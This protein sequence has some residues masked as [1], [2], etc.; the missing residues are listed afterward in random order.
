MSR[1]VWPQAMQLFSRGLTDA[2][3]SAVRTALAEVSRHNS[4]APKFGQHGLPVALRWCSL[5]A[6]GFPRQ[7]FQVFRRSGRVPLK[8]IATDRHISGE[9]SIEWGRINMFHVELKAQPDA[10]SSLTIHALDRSGRAIPG[11]TIAVAAP[12]KCRFRVAGVA[13][14]SVAG[15]G[16]ISGIFGANAN[17]V[18]N[19]NDWEL[20]EV[21]GLPFRKDEIAPPAYAP[22]PQGF[23]PAST[24]GVDAAATRLQL[25][26]MLH[27][28]LPP[29]GIAAIPTPDWPP[30]DVSAWLKFVRDPPDSVLKMIAKCLANT[31]DADPNNLQVAFLY[32]QKGPGIRQVDIPEAVAGADPTE[33]EIPVVGVTMLS[34]GSE[35]YSATGLGYG[36]IDFPPH[37]DFQFPVATEPA[38]SFSTDFDYMV[39]NTFMLADGIKVEVAALATGPPRSGNCRVHRR[40]LRRNRPPPSISRRRNPCS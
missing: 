2:D 32:S 12:S 40:A 20:I 10:G 23:P 3:P 13:A 35:S 4:K 33:F 28:P 5:P 11:Q 27:Q 25:A 29:T 31:N 9:G 37:S 30:P 21:V 19:L 36:T 7:P 15:E 26:T 1:H 14:L 8:S 6:L 34:V 22:H 38:M 16:Q 17:E 24:E 18:A 39:T